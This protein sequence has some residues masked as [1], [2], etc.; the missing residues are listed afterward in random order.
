M[1]EH[2]NQQVIVVSEEGGGMSTASL[3]IGVLGIVLN[4]IPFIS[5]TSWVLAFLA[6]IFG[7]IGIFQGKRKGSAKAGLILGGITLVL[8][9][10]VIL[11]LSSLF[12]LLF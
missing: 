1:D 6:I 8:K 12:A 9:F 3:V 2:S 5:L 10:V 4:F 7:G 11:F